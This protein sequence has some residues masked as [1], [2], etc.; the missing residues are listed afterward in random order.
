MKKLL[1][2][3]ALTVLFSL[4]ITCT[5]APL[6]GN[7]SEIT[8]G[9]CMMASVPADS[10]LV[11]AYPHDYQLSTCVTRPVTTYTD[12]NGKF[13][14]ILGDSAWNLLIYDRT[15]T[16]GAF[17]ALR[18]GDSAVGLV[19]LESLGYVQGTVTDSS[20]Q[21]GS[22]I[23]PGSPFQTSITIQNSF[24][25][26]KLP[27]FTYR[28]IIARMPNEGCAPGADCS[29]HQPPDTATHTV[30]VKAG[31]GTNVIIP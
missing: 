14:L 1:L 16:Y 11:V 17:I 2:L 10:A 13:F 5:L 9:V 22:V 29:G 20:Y 7:G 28:L 21:L 19:A 4:L 18:N 24:F 3:T 15:Q 12:K 8:N 31:S 25:I 30:T 23:I 6:A 27:E 26:S